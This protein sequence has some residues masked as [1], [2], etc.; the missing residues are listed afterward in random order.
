MKPGDLVVTLGAAFANE[1]SVS[2]FPRMSMN[3]QN[4][5]VSRVDPGSIGLVLSSEWDM[6]DEMWFIVFP[7]IVGWV[8]AKS[9]KVVR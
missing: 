6:A 7:D 5:L 1:C 8:F 3:D 9:V 2:M 4:P